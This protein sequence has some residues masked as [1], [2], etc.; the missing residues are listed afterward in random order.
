MAPTVQH[1]PVSCSIVPLEAGPCCLQSRN[2]TLFGKHDEH[3]KGPQPRAESKGLRPVAMQ[4]PWMV[5][6]ASNG[7]KV[8]SRDLTDIVE[9]SLLAT[10]T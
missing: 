5:S 8:E 9:E 3:I 1:M 6:H 2:G 7:I 4:G 10:L